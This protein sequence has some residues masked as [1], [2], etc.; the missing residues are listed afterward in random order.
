MPGA[1]IATQLCFYPISCAGIKTQAQ[2]K[3]CSSSEAD[4][5]LKSW[6]NAK[7]FWALW[8]IAPVKL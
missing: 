8:P 3:D 6:E 4:R 1:A 5:D 7:S 2:L